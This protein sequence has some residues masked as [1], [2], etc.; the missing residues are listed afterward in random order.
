LNEQQL[1]E[2]LLNDSSQVKAAQFRLLSKQS[3]F[4]W[5][6]S[7]V[8]DLRLLGGMAITTK[9]FNHRKAGLK[10]L[11]SWNYFAFNRNQG[12]VATACRFAAPKKGD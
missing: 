3:A 4:H 6:I 1:L 10:H 8:T 12:Q 7:G 2:T 9:R 5:Q 11:S